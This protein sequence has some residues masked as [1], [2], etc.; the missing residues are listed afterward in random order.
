MSSK[1]MNGA[2]VGEEERGERDRGRGRG[3]WGE[4][5]QGRERKR[6]RGK[7]K[8][9]EG[10]QGRERGKGRGERGEGREGEERRQKP[11]LLGRIC[12]D[13]DNSVLD[14]AQR[15]KFHKSYLTSSY[16]NGSTLHQSF[17][18]NAG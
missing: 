12:I 6:G 15:R 10:R 18:C 5:T 4:G 17:L 8:G 9:G 14:Q 1:E 2:R 11:N 16:P 7:G 13:T 3:K